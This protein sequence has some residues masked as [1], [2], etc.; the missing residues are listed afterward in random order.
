MTLFSIPE[1]M[2]YSLTF[3]VLCVGGQVIDHK[4]YWLHSYR[5]ALASMLH[6][7]AH[8]LSINDGSCKFLSPFAIPPFSSW[9][10]SSSTGRF[11]WAE[12]HEIAASH[13]FCETCW[14]LQS[15]WI[16]QQFTLLFLYVFFLVLSPSNWAP[17][18]LKLMS[19]CLCISRSCQTCES[20]WCW[21]ELM[22]NVTMP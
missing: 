5:S 13:E 15:M 18:M 12:E 7:K 10:A 11:S 8:S 3:D 2:Q 21:Y 14:F 1:K 4:G 17:W 20:S 16:S 22:Q 9:N 6:H 19:F